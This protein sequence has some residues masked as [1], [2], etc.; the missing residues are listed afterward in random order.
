MMAEDLGPA[1]FMSDMVAAVLDR[2]PIDH[3]VEVRNR[4]EQI[5][6]PLAEGEI[7]KDEPLEE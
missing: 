1:R 4:R 5:Q 6:L 7:N 2:T 3:H